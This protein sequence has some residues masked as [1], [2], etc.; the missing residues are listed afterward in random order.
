[1]TSADRDDWLFLCRKPP[2]GSAWGA[3]CLELLLTAAAFDR[4]CSLVFCGDGVY[5]LAPGQDGAAV[6]LKS[7]SHMLPALELYE[8][9][10]VLALAGDLRARG[11]D[12]A[13]LV[14][15]VEEID[16]AAL[17]RLMDDAA[18]VFVF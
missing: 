7:V 5:H 11:L 8:V 9:K 13:K 14:T 3:A 18:Q 17:S 16:K 2:Y 12:G 15:P 1:M 6:G 4:D 10:R